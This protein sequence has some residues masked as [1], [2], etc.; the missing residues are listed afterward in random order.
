MPELHDHGG[1]R[2]VAVIDD[3]GPIRVAIARL[4]RTMGY[5]TRMFASA[6]A[7]LAE[8]AHW[9][10]TC[11][12]TDIQMPGMNGL[13]LARELTKLLPTLPVLVMTAYPSLASRELALAAGASE[14]VTKPL[15]DQRLETWLRETIGPPA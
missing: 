7:M 15:D 4:L 14:Y 12:L 2:A 6:E 11:V 8:L 5:E 13:E 10:P 9:S 1:S 3:D